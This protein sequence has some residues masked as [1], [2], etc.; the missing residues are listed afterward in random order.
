M[1]GT[2]R[3]GS[4][5][6]G[7]GL[8]ST[9]IREDEFEV[10][11]RFWGGTTWGV[12]VETYNKVTKESN[13]RR[14]T[15]EEKLLPAWEAELE[16]TESQLRAALENHEPASQECGLCGP[17]VVCSCDYKTDWSVDHLIEALRK[18]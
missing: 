13:V 11:T 14:A 3:A 16:F 15:K 9:T 1:L 18:S 5:R 2:D 6:E 10:V 7:G 17:H 8:M 4:A 12:L